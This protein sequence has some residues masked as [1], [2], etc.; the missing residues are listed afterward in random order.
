MNN[1]VLFTGKERAGIATRKTQLLN[2]VSLIY[3]NKDNIFQIMFKFSVS[4]F[5]DTV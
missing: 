1:A 2:K 4:W 3:R 5:Y